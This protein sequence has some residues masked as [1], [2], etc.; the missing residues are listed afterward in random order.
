MELTTDF[1]NKVAQALLEGKK[2]FSGSDAAYARTHSI[3]TSVFSRLKGGETTHLLSD[4][5]WFS[6]GKRLGVTLNSRD[7]KTAPTQV[8]QMIE[9]EIVFCQTFAKARI[10]VDDCGIGK[11]YTA[12]WLSRNRRNCFYV[13]ASQSK[14]K[15][16]FIKALATAIGVDDKGKYAEIISNVKYYLHVLP[17]P[18]III[19]EAGDLDY[20]AFLEIK[21][22]WNATEN[23]CG[24]YMM[25]AEGLR[26]KIERGIN[27]RKVGYRE[28]FSRFSEKYSCI[29]PVDRLEK[30]KFYQKLITDV[31]TVN[32]VQ[33][34]LI[35]KIVNKCLIQ[36][37]GNIGGLR[38]AESLLILN[39]MQNG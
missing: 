39:N 5:Q 29:V 10:F 17:Q 38:R 7:W 21:E 27:H 24:W 20:A 28:I 11:T 14:T 23:V 9:E 16:R 6:I 13:D 15:H 2:Q 4:Q 35:P 1:K 32:S 19:D 3:H 12:K 36:Q 30:Q 26:A 25:G 8:F 22:L 18:I 31:L 37:D 34:E 33:K